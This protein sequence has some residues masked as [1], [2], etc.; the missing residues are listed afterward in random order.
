MTAGE[1]EVVALPY[2]ARSQA[3]LW[4][5]SRGTPYAELR[6]INGATILTLAVG[7]AGYVVHPADGVTVGDRLEIE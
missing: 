2:A 1:I 5:S 7:P 4:R 6:D 3:L